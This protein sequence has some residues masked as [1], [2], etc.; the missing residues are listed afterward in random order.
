MGRS[1]PRRG[2]PPRSQP[3]SHRLVL[4]ARRQC[5][6]FLSMHAQR[7]A[8]R[9]S[10]TL[11]HGSRTPEVAQKGASAEPPAF[12]GCGWRWWPC[13]LPTHHPAALAAHSWAPSLLAP[14]GGL[15]ISSCSQSQ[16][17]PTSWRAGRP[18]RGECTEAGAP[19]G[20]DWPPN[21]QPEWPL[22]R[23]QLREDNLPALEDP[24]PSAAL[25][26]AT[27]EALT[28]GCPGPSPAPPRPWSSEVL[29][30]SPSLPGYSVAH[31]AR[32]LRSPLLLSWVPRHFPQHASHLESLQD[33]ASGPAPSHSSPHALHLTI[34]YHRQHA[35]DFAGSLDAMGSVAWTCQS[36]ALSPG[37]SSA[38]DWLCHCGQ[39]PAPLWA[40]VAP[41]VQWMGWEWDQQGP[42]LPSQTALEGNLV[43]TL[44]FR[45]GVLSPFLRCP[46]APVGGGLWGT[47]HLAWELLS[48]TP[49]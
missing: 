48:L 47:E 43:A 5:Y 38:P 44:C 27:R 21:R 11:A 16:S 41:S 39:V 36:G 4:A 25:S 29:F 12:P 28:T 19:R 2:G 14:R 20:Q 45:T 46:Q 18:G 23:L 49:S 40:S 33:G 32:G 26:A 24:G 9:G 1:L 15:S 22:R 34:S 30:P 35:S 42:R 7:T 8:L 37:P 10:P 13:A 31:P 3:S 17:V 6:G